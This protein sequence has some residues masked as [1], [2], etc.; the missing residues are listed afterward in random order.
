MGQD[1]VE[2]FLLKTAEENFTKYL[3]GLVCRHNELPNLD[4]ASASNIV[5]NNLDDLTPGNNDIERLGWVTDSDL[6]P[7]KRAINQLIALVKEKRPAVVV[8]HSQGNLLANLAWFKL[9]AD[10][11]NGAN[12]AMRLVNVGN[13]AVVSVHG[14]N[15]TH[16]S[17]LAL[18]NLQLL[19]LISGARQ[20]DRCT[21]VC[22][23]DVDTKHCPPSLAGIS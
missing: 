19:P 15:F 21:G 18:A 7:T 13:A 17:D 20:T 2:L 11:G 1:L 4:A 6:E 8:A 23:F 3:P 5:R 9:V 14:L 22:V 16:A 12:S 10:F